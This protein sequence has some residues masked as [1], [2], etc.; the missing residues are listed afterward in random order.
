VKGGLLQ[1]VGGA[2]EV[3]PFAGQAH[4]VAEFAGAEFDA[5]HGEEENFLVDEDVGGAGDGGLD[6]AAAELVAAFDALRNAE[7]EGV[8]A[9][10]GHGEGFHAGGLFFKVGEV[11]DLENGVD[12]AL[13]DDGEAAGDFVILDFFEVGG[14]VAH[15]FHFFLDLDLEGAVAVGFFEELVFE[16]ELGD[17]PG[18]EAAGGGGDGAVGA[19]LGEVVGEDAG[20]FDEGERD[21]KDDGDA[22]GGVGVGLVDECDEL[23]FELGAGGAAELGAENSWGEETEDS[24]QSAEAEQS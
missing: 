10:V 11:E 5:G 9:E 8:G 19:A 14:R 12:V 18:E 17:I 22:V 20:D 6:G 7:G 4:D 15:G 21:L 2:Q 13:A 1:V 24:S 23:V 3:Y 16:G